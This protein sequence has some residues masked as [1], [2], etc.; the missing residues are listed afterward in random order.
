MTPRS[1]GGSTPASAANSGSQSRTVRAIGPAWSN[2]GESGTIPRIETSPRVGLIVDVPHSAEGMRSE[3]AVSVPVAAATWRDASAAAEPPLEPPAERS[4]AHGLPTWSV[5]PPQANSCV[6][7]WPEQHHPLGGEPRP[8]VAVALGHVLEHAAGRGQRLAGDGVEVL[9][10]DR[11]ATE[12][13]RIASGEPLVRGR[14][15]SERVL[16]VDAR[17]GVDRVGIA[18]VAVY[19]V[20]LAD[21]GEARLDELARGERSRVEGDGRV[22]DSEVCRIRHAPIIAAGHPR[23]CYTRLRMAPRTTPP[24]RAD[25]VGSLL[26]P[27]ALLQGREDRAA[28]S[29][30]QR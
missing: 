7:R 5:V 25:H 3:P 22:L 12:L 14:G 30:R 26:R 13:G 9:Q 29:N 1:R 23:P 10:P 17:P 15:R 21:P 19:A 18:V 6:C 27:P 16:L 28:G 24:F 20:P 2:V 11:D 8:R 4:S